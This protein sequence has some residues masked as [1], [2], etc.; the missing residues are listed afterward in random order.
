MAIPV[1]DDVPDEVAVLA[2]PFAVSLHS[3]TRNPPPP[4]GRALVWG[5]G[6][7]GTCA[8]AILRAL[9]PDVEV[10]AVVRHPAQQE[11]ARRL[12]ATVLDAALDDEA[13][14]VELAEWSGGRLHKPWAGLPLTHPGHIDVCYDTIASPKTIELALRVLAERGDDRVERRARRGTLRVVAVVLQGGPHR[15]ARTRSASKRSTA[16]ASTRSSTTS[17]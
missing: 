12:G 2:D 3:I 14:V 11:L 6:A 4:G 15:R 10:A 1:P 13:L 5:A 17:T 16:S 7:L 8:I 9:H